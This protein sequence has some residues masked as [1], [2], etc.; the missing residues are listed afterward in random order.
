MADGTIKGTTR[1]GQEWIPHFID[2]I[3]QSKCI[4]CGRCYKACGRDVLVLTE[5]E[6]DDDMLS[7]RMSVGNADDCVGCSAC[8]RVCTKKCQILNPLMSVAES[9]VISGG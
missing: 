3:D 1:G 7:Q 8:L 2:D 5:F 4:G 9:K 6:E